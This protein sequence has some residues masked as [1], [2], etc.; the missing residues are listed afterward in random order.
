[1]NA[2]RILLADD[3]RLIRAGIRALLDTVAYFQ[4]AGEARDGA[5]ALR[6]VAELKPDLVIM[7]VAMPDLSGLQAL[8]TMR[9]AGSEVKVV[10]LSM[11]AS[12]EH[13]IRALGLGASGYVVKD[14][15][16][17][18]LE[19][20]IRAALRDE[21]WLP[22]AMPRAAIDDYAERVGKRRTGDV[23]TPRQKQVLKLIAE[24][25]GTREIATN[26]GLSVKTIE[27][28]RAQIMVRLDIQDIPGL[29]RY[30]IRHGISRL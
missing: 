10:M 9:I 17:G 13:I 21:I 27:T 26:L 1:M 6:L 11:H 15:A 28:Y 8:E 20:A 25:A 7:D 22:S 5:E 24:G 14:A 2:I 23:L 3:H 19:A 30:A 18:E 4:V 29:V 12:E 16:P